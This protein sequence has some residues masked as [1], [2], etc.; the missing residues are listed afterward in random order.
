M[1][2][3]TYLY[4]YV[5]KDDELYRVVLIQKENII[6]LDCNGLKEMKNLIGQIYKSY[7]YVITVNEL[8]Y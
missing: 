2:T 4:H 6:S 1:N 7:D 5:N 8:T 3:K